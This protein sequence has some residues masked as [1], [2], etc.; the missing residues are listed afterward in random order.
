MKNM[1]RPFRSGLQSEGY[2][3]FDRLSMRIAPALIALVMCA[4]A[5]AEAEEGFKLGIQ[6]RIRVHVYDWP[7]L[8]GEFTVDASGKISLPLLGEVAAAGLELSQVSR[9]ISERLKA[10][11]GT[12][13]LPDTSVSI[14]DYGPF[15]IFGWVQRPGEYPFRPGMMTLS[16][17]SAAGG[18][19]RPAVDS[20]WAVFRDAVTGYSDV[21]VLELKRAQLTA[22][23]TRLRAELEGVDF[24]PP[25]S[26]DSQVFVALE[27]G[28]FNARRTKRDAEIEALTRRSSLY[29]QELETLSE[30]RKAVAKD[31]AL[32]EGELR[33]IQG[34][35][36]RGLTT[37][38][39]GVVLERSIAQ[40]EREVLD[41][42]TQVLR[43]RQQIGI[44]EQTIA[45]LANN[46]KL[47]AADE[48]AKVQTEARQIIPRREAAL[49]ML[50]GSENLIA[51]GDSNEPIDALDS[52]YFEITRKGDDGLPHQ[53]QA[54]RT[55]V[56]RPG[57]ILEVRNRSSQQAPTPGTAD[58]S[59]T[60][61]NRSNEQVR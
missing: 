58:I 14:I 15:Y 2:F 3:A 11:A 1:S 12:L 28:L 36:A 19:Y 4:V 35:V 13:D 10:K 44:A 22:S 16:A 61:P 60:K 57:D 38:A 37:A 39:Q 55:T 23:E 24:S 48:L 20:G 54:A 59:A 49:R 30:Q 7:Q 34:L 33:R 52:I 46:Y 17:I 9:I 29:L 8:T 51:G 42:D 5:P 47:E 41:I 27:V 53:I 32:V 56:L 26:T 6:H 45:T 43:A 31:R 18:F 50:S 40:I 25:S 21:K